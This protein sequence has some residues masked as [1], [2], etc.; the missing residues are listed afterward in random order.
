MANQTAAQQAEKIVEF[1]VGTARHDEICAQREFFNSD[2]AFVAWYQK[3]ESSRTVVQTAR[4]IQRFWKALG[5]ARTFS[6]TLRAVK[7][8]LLKLANAGVKVTQKMAIAVLEELTGKKATVI[9]KAA[10]KQQLALI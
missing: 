6:I 8:A 10:L 4:L 2:S 1:H 3:S 7:A 9:E 5:I